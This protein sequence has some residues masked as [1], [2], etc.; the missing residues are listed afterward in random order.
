MGTND[1]RRPTGRDDERGMALIMAIL[2]TILV[3]GIVTTGTLILR[4]HQ[5]KTN[6]SFIA[7]GQAV[8]FARS[9]L[10]EALGWFRKQT[11]QPVLSF[12]PQLDTGVVPPVLDTIDPDIGLVREFSIE[13]TIWGRYEVWK[14]WAG[15]PDPTRLA[16]RE[17]MQAS[18]ISSLRGNLTDGSVWRI[19]CIGYVYKLVDPNVR[20]DVAPNHVLGKEIAEC[21]ARRLALQPPGQA[22]LCATNGSD[23]TIGTRGR[24]IGGATA[25]GIYYESGTGTASVSGTGSSLTGTPTQAAAV[26]YDAS[27]DY[28]FGVSVEELTAMADY[29]VDA[30]V[31]FPS[32]VPVDTVVMCNTGITF[33][34]SKPLSGTGVVVCLGDTTVSPGSNS[35]FSGLLYVDGNLT[36]REPCEIQGAVVVTGTV[37]VLGD[38][39]Y[40]TITY[41][42]AILQRLRQ[43]LGTYRLSS[44]I[45]RPL[46][47]DR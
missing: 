5:T 37:T 46:S 2:F 23:V 19:R 7:K 12:A 16:F 17:Q 32:P 11:S 42:D 6:V 44:A 4:G 1:L 8:Q 21:E 35:S 45:A 9:G 22:A 31:D 24:V 28:V 39:D 38:S 15:D 25:A 29:V 33:T 14:E 36:L 27:F 18:D 41:D 3:V 43:E 34:A 10:I 40:A 20:F 26:D 13:N 30:A 47:S